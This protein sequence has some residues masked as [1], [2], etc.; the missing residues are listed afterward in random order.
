MIGMGQ[1]PLRD[2]VLATKNG[3]HDHDTITTSKSGRS[4]GVA[5]TQTG[6]TYLE[7]VDFDERSLS[8][9]RKRGVVMDVDGEGWKKIED[10]KRKLGGTLWVKYHSTH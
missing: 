10:G 2:A 7:N 5:V 4:L 1:Q 3:S 8:G 9:C 6:S